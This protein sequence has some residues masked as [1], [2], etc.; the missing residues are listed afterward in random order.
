MLSWGQFDENSV[1]PP[2]QNTGAITA[3]LNPPDCQHHNH[4]HQHQHHRRNQFVTTTPEYR[5]EHDNMGEVRVP[6]T[7]LYGA[8]T[9]RAVENFTLSGSVLEPKQIQALARINHAAS[10]PNVHLAVLDAS[11][12]DAITAAD[13]DVIAGSH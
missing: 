8:Q 13:E 9:Q 3:H 6:A 11:I 7:A 2:Q 12:V 1:C 10:Q 5:I 4:N